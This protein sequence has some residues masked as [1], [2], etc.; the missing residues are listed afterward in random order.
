MRLVEQRHAVNR[1]GYMDR[2]R[3]CAV[4]RLIC[5]RHT[6]FG[7]A[8]RRPIRLV[9]GGSAYSASATDATS[10][11]VVRIEDLVGANTSLGTA[12]VPMDASAA[13]R[14]L[15][16]VSSRAGLTN[17]SSAAVD[18]QLA[19]LH[20]HVGDYGG[21]LGHQSSASRSSV[22]MLMAA[23]TEA[24]D[25]MSALGYDLYH[26]GRGTPSAPEVLS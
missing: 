3:R 4:V 6:R 16:D 1:K 14:I 22:E 15:T 19:S 23:F 8:C 5:R 13:E 10:L 18:A 12:G 21:G 20:Q 24:H 11:V 25:V 17:V 2:P 9:S 7:H 26:Y